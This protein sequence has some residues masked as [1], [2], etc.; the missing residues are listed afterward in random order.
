MTEIYHPAEDSK[1]LL[2]AVISFFRELKSKKQK[3]KNFRA[4][5]LGTGSGILAGE[6]RRG[7][8]N[9]DLKGEVFATDINK[10][11][12]KKVK[13]KTEN[14]TLVLSDLFSS[15]EERFDLAVFNPPYLP[16]DP[17]TD[18]YLKDYWANIIDRGT[19]E[20]FLRQLP[21][22][23]K[24]SGVCLLLISTLTGRERVEKLLEKSGLNFEVYLREKLSFE[25]L[26]VYRI[27]LK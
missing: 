21:E 25:E 15:L 18:R 9:L 5:D 7:M 10:E 2:K 20:R 26:I 6:I 16:P 22:Y 3:T 13:Q 1:L 12:L 4:V 23:L 19:V 27:S 8:D 14:I 11:A 24:D 17:E